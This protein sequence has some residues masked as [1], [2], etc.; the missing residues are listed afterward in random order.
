MKVAQMAEC[1]GMLCQPHNWARCWTTRSTS[2]ARWPRM[3]PTKG[4]VRDDGSPMGS[5]DA[6]PPVLQGP[7]S[8]I[9]K[10]ATSP[11]PANR[12]SATKFDYDATSQRVGT[13][14]RR[15]KGTDAFSTE[16]NAPVPFQNGCDDTSDHWPARA[17]RTHTRG[18]GVRITNRATTWPLRPPVPTKL[19][20]CNRSR[21][22]ER[23]SWRS[24]FALCK[25][26][27][28]TR[29]GR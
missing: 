8:A 10:T 9:D 27:L 19:H 13:T 21:T 4:V 5:T 22:G 7:G 12:A 23:P 14:S 17:T 15:R 2:I 29:R 18:D 25:G 1:F 28:E 24:T 26:L 6:G 16:G 3:R 11:R 20:S